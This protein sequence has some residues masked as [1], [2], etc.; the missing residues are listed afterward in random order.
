MSAISLPIVVV[1]IFGPVIA[2]LIISNIS[3]RWIFYVNVPMCLA[4]LVLAWRQLPAAAAGRRGHAS[5]WSDWCCCRP[6]WWRC[7]TAWPR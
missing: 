1:P 5:T 6:R 3:W 4:G 7:C 2:G